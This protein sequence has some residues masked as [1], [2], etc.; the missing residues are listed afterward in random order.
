MWTLG[1]C[2][3]AFVAVSEL[4]A[5][6]EARAAPNSSGFH[7]WG[8][9]TLFHGLPSDHVR[10]IAQAADG[11]MWFGTDAGLVKYDGR[12]I[13]RVA[14]DGWISGQI[15]ALELD[16]D[17]ALW[18][19]TN[20]GAA[21]LIRGEINPIADTEG[22]AVTAIIT[23]SPRQTIMT[24][25]RGIVLYASLREDGSVAVRK[26]TPENNPLLQ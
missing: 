6:R 13:Q 2:V 8:A 20:S 19:G 17:G 10:A 3:F 1:L 23:A 14:T 7:Q 12:R 25:E 5:M 4:E 11:T 26:I 18:I 16:A 9:I 21:R 15:R 24:S 22:I